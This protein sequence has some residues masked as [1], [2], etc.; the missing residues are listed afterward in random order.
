MTFEKILTDLTFDNMTA[1]QAY[2][3]ICQKDKL[4]V[5]NYYTH[6]ENITKEPLKEGQLQELNAI[7]GIL[8]ILYNASVGSPISDSSYD[9]LQEMLIDLG[10]PRLTG[11]I[12]IK[13]GRAHF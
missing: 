5:I 9:T 6:I 12:E 4:K 10:I 13:I 3:Q 7:V 11:S 1:Q 8:Q 2:N